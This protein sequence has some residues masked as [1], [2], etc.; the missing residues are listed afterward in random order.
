M[1]VYQ[2]SMRSYSGRDYGRTYWHLQHLGE[3]P[4]PAAVDRVVGNSSMTDVPE[5]QG[6]GAKGL[7]G[8][9]RFGED[10]GFRQSAAH[11]CPDCLKAASAM[12][13][14]GER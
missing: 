2:A 14:Y 5:C 10:I 1:N 7:P 3:N 9:F 11:V 8:V 12:L 4:S 6:C 13:P